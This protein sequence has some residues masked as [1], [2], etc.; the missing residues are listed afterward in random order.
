LIYILIE[1]SVSIY[2]VSFFT[3][4]T[5][6]II[7]IRYFR[8]RYT[9]SFQ[10]YLIFIISVFTL[11]FITNKSREKEKNIRQ[12][13]VVNLANERDQIAEFLLGE[14]ENNLR[15]DEIIKTSLSSPDHD[16]YDLIGYLE[17]NYFGGYF[18]KYELQIASCGHGCRSS[19]G[20]CE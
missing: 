7:W 12:V 17:N 6:S 2:A 16:D 11:A 18:R 15:N 4:M 20:G 8:Y 5:G 9:Y 1:E 14:I 10:L 19:A 13:L 3:V